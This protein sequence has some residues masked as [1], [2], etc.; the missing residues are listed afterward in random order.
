VAGASAPSVLTVFV[1]GS[2]KI[3]HTIRF[4]MRQIVPAPIDAYLAALACREDDVLK[5]IADEGRALGVPI[6]EAQVG[7]LL[8]VLTL[9]VGAR[10]VLEIGTGNGYSAVWLARAL[11][12]GGTLF[13][14]EIDSERAGVARRNLAG[15]GLEDRVTVMNDDAARLVHKMAGPFDLVFNDGDKRQYGPLLDRLVALLRPGG[16]LVT[17]NV[18]WSGEVV[19]GFVDQPAHPAGETRAIAAYNEQL[20]SHDQLTTTFVPL[21]D[22]VAVAVKTIAD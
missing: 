9:A 4:L 17:D 12:A 16:L 15:A 13:T 20:A 10:Q 22:G 2:T 21:R 8:F 5:R 6:V 19:P 7:T 11:P 14:I 3:Q 18:L 1:N